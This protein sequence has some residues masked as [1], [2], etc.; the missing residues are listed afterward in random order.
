MIMSANQKVEKVEN[1]YC[2]KNCD[3]FTYKKTDFT[4]HLQT[5]KHN[6]NQ[7]AN[8]ANEKE[9]KKF[10]CICDK[11]FLHKS[12]LARHKRICEKSKKSKIQK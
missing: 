7:N 12:S 5:I 9:I 3:Y 4:K 1:K 6:A 8:N 10:I 2:C 11:I